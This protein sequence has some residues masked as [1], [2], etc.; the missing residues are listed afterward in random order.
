MV[1]F[2][3]FEV[4]EPG[5]ATLFFVLGSGDVIDDDEPSFKFS[6]IKNGMLAS[7]HA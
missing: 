6:S 1:E 7:F 4:A 5:V 2:E 3:P